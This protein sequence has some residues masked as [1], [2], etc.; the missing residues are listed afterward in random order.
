[1]RIKWTEDQCKIFDLENFKKGKVIVKACPGSGKTLC[2]SERIIRFINEHED[3]QSGLAILSFTNVAIDEISER[4]E[5]E[6]NEKIVYPHFIG[7]I[8][9]FINKYIFLP[10]GH[11]VMNCKKKTHTSWRAICSMAS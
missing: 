7:T 3:N 5:K 1:M 10:F 6:T 2:V 4:Y 8:D 11:L 9:S